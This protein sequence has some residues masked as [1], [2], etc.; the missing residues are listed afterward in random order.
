MKFISLRLS[1]LQASKLKILLL[2]LL[3]VS[4][5]SFTEPEPERNARAVFFS[6]VD[7]MYDCLGDEEL[8][9]KALQ[10]GLK[11]YYYLMQHRKV[12]NDNYLAIVDFSLPSDAE[13]LFI[14]DLEKHEI[15]KRSLV[16]HGMK[17]GDLYAKDFSNESE[18]HQSSLGFYVTGVVYNGRHDESLKL[19]GLEKE[20]NDNAYDRGVVIHAAQ[21]AT[22]EFLE[23]NG[24]V[25]GRSYGCP[26]LPFEGYEETIGLLEKGTCV[27]IY[28]PDQHYLQKSRPI[29][30]ST[31]YVH[32]ME[33]Y[34]S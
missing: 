28:Y 33:A 25:L 16:S 20:F 31:G 30:S 32:F 21:Y 23:S 7:S 22:R 27:F 5:L 19:H 10:Y 17:T 24:N 34:N 9:Y 11:G 18:S 4:S 1:I 15:V 2:T 13:R 3:C 14:I 29:N 26:A 8:S 12:S 6:Y